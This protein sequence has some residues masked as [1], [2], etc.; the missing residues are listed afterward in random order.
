[1]HPDHLKSYRN[2]S[3]PQS[4]EEKKKKRFFDT[5]DGI[6]QKF[7]AENRHFAQGSQI[8]RMADYMSLVL[9]DMHLE[10]GASDCTDC[11]G[12]RCTMFVH[13][14]ISDERYPQS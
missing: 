9:A 11:T 12:E 7:R 4:T 5:V 13:G 3:T 8:S 10:Y 14:T 6:V 1:M 2:C